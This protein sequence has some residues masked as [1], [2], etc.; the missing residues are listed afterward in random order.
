MM[1]PKV[2]ADHEKLMVLGQRRFTGFTAY[3]VVTFLNQ[4][5]KERE[6]IFGL[7]QVGD[8]FELTVYDGANGHAT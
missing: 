2:S 8:D 3:Q 4:I 6:I 1:D 7:R 5:L